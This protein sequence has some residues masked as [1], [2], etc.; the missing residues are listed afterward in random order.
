MLVTFSYDL[1]GRENTNYHT[2]T[3]S[4]KHDIYP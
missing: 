1:S 3:F 2:S 4:E